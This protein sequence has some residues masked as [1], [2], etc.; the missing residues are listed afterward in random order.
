MEQKIEPYLKGE[1][2][3]ELFSKSRNTLSELHSSERE[4]LKKDYISPRSSF[5][6]VGC[7]SGNLGNIILSEIEQKT[8]YTGIDVEMC[9]I[10]YGKR[11]FK[12]SNLELINGKF[13]DGV[14]GRKFDYICVFNLFEQIE[15]WKVFLTTLSEMARKY[16]NIG[17]SLRM[18]GNT[19]VDIDSSFGYYFDS[20]LRVHKIVHNIY[21][22]FNFCCINE[23]RVRKV[24]FYGYNINLAHSSRS[25]FR[26][27]SQKEEIRGNLFLELLPFEKTLKR[28]G[29]LKTDVK[30]NSEIIHC[31]KPEFCIIING[32][33]ITF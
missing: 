11:N 23:M 26:A 28:Y 7:A 31:T 16:I 33:R 18:S 6:D 8:N 19:V 32:K 10:E 2:S 20:G 13:P 14:E 25:D 9:G 17:L 3:C 12:S 21:Q 27:I 4:F 24:N 5:L 29:A 30:H 22:I 15:N 1:L